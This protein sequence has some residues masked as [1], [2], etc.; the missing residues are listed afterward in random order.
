MLSSLPF[1]ALAADT[2]EIPQWDVGDKWAIGYE[3]SYDT[4]DMDLQN[5]SEIMKDLY[6]ISDLSVDGSSYVGVWSTFK[7]TG[8]SG[9]YYTLHYKA[10]VKAK[11]GLSVSFTALTPTEGT[12]TF[13]SIKNASTEERSM[14]IG[15]HY[16]F[17][18]MAEGDILI[19][20]STMAIDNITMNLEEKLDVGLTG[21]NTPS[22]EGYGIFGYFMMYDKY[23]MLAS[24]F[25]LK[26]EDTNMRMTQSFSMNVWSEYSPGLMLA[27]FP[28]YEGKQWNQTV[29]SKFGGTYGGTI[30]ASGLP[31]M[32]K[33]SAELYAG[34]EFPID[35]RKMDLGKQFENGIIKTDRSTGN[36]SLSCEGTRYI[37]GDGGNTKVFLIGEARE[38]YSEEYSRGYADGYDDGYSD[39]QSGDYDSGYYYDGAYWEGYHSGYSDGYYDGEY[40]GYMSS[41]DDTSYYHYEAPVMPFYM[42]YSPD[43]EFFAGIYIDRQAFGSDDIMP[44]NGEMKQVASALNVAD[45]SEIPDDIGFMDFDRASESISST[46]AEMNGETSGFSPIMLVLVLAVVAIAAMLGALFIIKRR[47]AAAQAPAY[48]YTQQ[49]ERNEEQPP[50]ENMQMQEPPQPPNNGDNTF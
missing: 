26:Y 24:P 43:R 7:V 3:K 5:L 15:F 45:S 34:Q 50:P 11:E 10:A 30:D 19:E 41:Y 16:S 4:G 22:V 12:Y 33:N 6:N 25:E 49:V 36:I 17:Y 46:E 35:M 37:S 29:I 42:M 39:G 32:V 9:A 40:Y 21:K 8:D 31:L 47:K 13:D 44:M 38:N 27:D 14:E 2:A 1:S 18:V 23:S 20:K 28:L 48:E